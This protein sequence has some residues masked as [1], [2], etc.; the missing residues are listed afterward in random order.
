MAS[1]RFTPPRPREIA[2]FTHWIGGWVGP[3]YGL[4]VAAKRKPP[5]PE[6]QPVTSRCTDLAISAHAISTENDI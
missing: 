1:G 6:I 5:N 4:D 2:P 3:R